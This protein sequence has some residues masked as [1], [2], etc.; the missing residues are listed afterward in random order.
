MSPASFGR[1]AFVSDLQRVG[2][3]AETVG[4]IRDVLR[5]VLSLA[6]KSG[7]L[8]ANPVTGIEV[9]RTARTDAS[10]SCTINE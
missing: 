1:R 9:A 10:Q 8:K 6:V 5:L 3:G 4:S 2:V 7:A